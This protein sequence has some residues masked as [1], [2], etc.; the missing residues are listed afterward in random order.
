MHTLNPDGISRKAVFYPGVRV[1]PGPKSSL[2]E[3][4]GQENSKA[5]QRTKFVHAEKQIISTISWG[6]MSLPYLL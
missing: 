2:V 6:L 5:L 1:L 3:D 4:L